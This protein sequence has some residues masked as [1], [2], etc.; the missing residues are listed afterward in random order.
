MNGSD[1]FRDADVKNSELVELGVGHTGIQYRTEH[2]DR[3][4]AL[5]TYSSRT[6]FEVVVLGVGIDIHAHS[7]AKRIPTGRRG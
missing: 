4:E 7:R 5:K 6:G 2:G 3:W 1:E